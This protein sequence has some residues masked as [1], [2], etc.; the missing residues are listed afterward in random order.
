MDDENVSKNSAPRRGFLTWLLGLGVLVALGLAGL[1]YWRS[2]QIQQGVADTA[3]IQSGL[4]TQLL[5]LHGTLSNLRQS[6]TELQQQM[7]DLLAAH[8]SRR[9]QADSLKARLGNLE[10]AVAELAEQQHDSNGENLHLDTTAFLLRM[11]QARM[12]LFHD[13]AG[14]L[15]ALNLATQALNEAHDP[16][17][18]PVLQAI[19]TERSALQQVQTL[20]R[21]AA[22]QQLGHLRSQVWSLPLRPNKPAKL[23]GSGAWSRIRSALSVLVTIR[24]DT[25]TRLDTAPPQLLH[26]LLALDLAQAQA[27][28]LG[29]Q[30]SG[31]AQG[32]HSSRRLLSTQFDLGNSQVQAFASSLRSLQSLPVTRKPRL[33]T[34]LETLGRLRALQTLATPP[35]PAKQASSP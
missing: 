12:R 15:N 26:S 2:D 14:A 30:R 1:S 5:A 31:Y 10:A 33:G 11:A 25:Q 6:R 28:L 34:A 24:H 19:N 8:R 18:A 4:Q 27:A 22:L 20:Q 21:A 23:A 32:L 29:Y 16:T 13:S 35:V 7:S 9:A 3:A 17:Y